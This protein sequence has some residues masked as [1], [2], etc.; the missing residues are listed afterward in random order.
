MG[1][2][3]SILQMAMLIDISDDDLGDGENNSSNCDSVLGEENEFVITNND[4]TC[5]NDDNSDNNSENLGTVSQI[6]ENIGYDSDR[7]AG[8]L[9]NSDD[10][11]SD[12]DLESDM[13]QYSDSDNDRSIDSDNNTSHDDSDERGEADNTNKTAKHYRD[14]HKKRK[15]KSLLKRKIA[16]HNWQTRK[17]NKVMELLRNDDIQHFKHIWND[18]CKMKHMNALKN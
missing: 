16:F 4:E 2:I 18:L 7:D 3:I 15:A 9:N 8:D 5:D 6:A 1:S 10:N 11:D 14:K 17:Y 12:S 13:N